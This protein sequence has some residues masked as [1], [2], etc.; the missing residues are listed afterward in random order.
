MAD[1]D[2]GLLKEITGVAV[3]IGGLILAAS[4]SIFVTKK[5]FKV[6][7]KSVDRKLYR[8]DG[9]TI[10][11]TKNEY[12]T[13]IGEIHKCNKELT[14][15]VVPRSEWEKSKEYREKRSDE[16]QRKLCGQIEKVTASME[17]MQISQNKTN[18][19]IGQLLTKFET[20][21]DRCFLKSR[22]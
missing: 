17:S 10:Y 7:L 19:V 4:K 16:I 2:W 21:I 5:E 20:Y 11:I 1:I 9:T 22:K 14:A 8:E 3:V 15:A 18:V 13:E 12:S 6:L